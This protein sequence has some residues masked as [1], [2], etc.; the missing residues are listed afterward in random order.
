MNPLHALISAAVGH[1]WMVVALTAAFALLGLH[2]F[3]SMVF[4][5][6][7]DL[8]NVQVQVLTT[9]PGLGAEEVERLVTLPVE[10]SLGGAPNVQT[11]RSLS[12]PGVSA[13]SVIFEDHT[14][15]W[16]ARQIVNEQLATARAEIPP[17]AG[18]PQ[19]GPRTTGLGEVYQL[20]VRSDARSPAELYR[21]FSREI[22]PRLRGVPG[23]VEVNA[24]GAGDPRLEVQLDP[25]ALA[26]RGLSWPEVE[27]A[28]RGGLGLA[29]GGDLPAGAERVGVRALSNPLRPEELGQLALRAED[30]AVV[31]LHE[32]ATI[33]PGVAPPV[34]MGSADG[35]GEALFAVVQLLAGA[36]ALRTVQAVRA[37][38]D[39]IR[40]SLPEDVV[41]EVIYD[42]EALVGN[43]LRTVARS[44]AEGGLLVVIV[45]L[46][47]LGD[48]RAGL[49]VAS[50][51]PLSLLGAFTGLWLTGGSGNL[52]SLGA[53]D[54]GL[55]V[56]GTIVL[57]EGIVGMDAVVG[58]TAA[59]RAE[60]V[61]GAAQRVS[62]PVLFAVLI[63]II[64][65][66]P[67]LGMVGTEGK[68][69]RPMALTVLFALITALVLTFTYVPAIS[70]LV[71]Q[72]K[73]HHTTPLL[74]L[75]SRPYLP[76]L[77]SLLA[78][79][80]AA[81]LGAAGLVGLG[82][83]GASQLGLEFVP[84]L[85]EGDLVVQTARLPS[86]SAAEALAETT[87]VERALRRFPE[88]IR[89]ASRTG[90]PALATDPMGLEETDV[91]VRLRPKDQWTT[92]PDM[93]GLVA[94][95]EAAI[96][97]EAPGA[98]LTFTQPIE[99]RF[100]ELLEG[101][102]SD[103]G[104]QI[105]GEDLVA[106]EAAGRAVAAALEG[107]PGAADV[108][109]PAAEGTPGL[110]LHLDP[111]ALARLGVDAAVPR[112][113]VSALQRGVPVGAL[114]R[115][116]VREEVVLTV[117]LARGGALIDLPFVAGRDAEGPVVHTLG[118]V[119]RAEELERPALVRR[120]GGSRRVS[121]L[122]NVRGRDLGAFVAE[123]TPLVAKVKL[124]PGAYIRWSGKMEQLR[125]AALR[126]ALTVPAALA[127]IFALLRVALG[128]TKAAA[129]IS[130]NVPA[131]ASGGVFA[132]LLTGQPLSMSAVVGFIALFGV[133]VMNGVVLVSR[134]RE[135]HGAP[136][137]RAAGAAA[138][139][140]QERFRPV[141]MTALVAGIGFLPMA[142]AT[143]VGAEVQRPLAT[144]VLG[145]LLT[146]TPL[147]LLL[148]PALYARLFADED[149]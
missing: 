64:V 109:A 56:D 124:P 98:A 27:A 80:R 16:L 127:V 25:Y 148:L 103:V 102:P 63:L 104:V 125:A 85:E 19:L 59:A 106:L 93:A 138:A 128:S 67:I 126:T 45:L 1:R 130:L 68:L 29:A 110:D 100:N 111:G 108:K 117:G 7:P 24:W 54:F 69:F 115:G 121:V 99:M 92:A 140:A 70:A 90:S 76:A 79:P 146:A 87:R 53:I 89:V 38:L 144:V 58:A 139:S 113:L 118:D 145:G 66:L 47:L 95:M 37:R 141:L 39:E 3:R 35:E 136:E 131:A 123:A 132:L 48:L 33:T 149:A 31:Q 30:G 143:G 52:M 23:V 81:A 10:R 9:A 74:R 75:L 71:V 122:A 60:A 78:R 147:T 120:Q 96:E 43:T 73:G 4:D 8:T 2:A 65:Y 107:V 142:L 12:R 114:L 22:A 88:V 134:T 41:V 129:L 40:P 133:A 42:R 86:I 116:T 55:V 34:G 97:A 62:R 72:P 5:A 28:V 20:S 77:A 137:G 44:L 13:V 61:R 46:L 84:R 91:L 18:V 26:A 36:D 105:Y 11:V 112:A 135:L 57:V 83:L 6:F 32:V 15:P 51:I 94:A 119:A 101:V 14:D 17:D 82:A 21:L 50:V 49:V